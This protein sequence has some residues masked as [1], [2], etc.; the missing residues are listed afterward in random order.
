MSALRHPVVITSLEEDFEKIGLIKKEDRLEEGL[1]VSK[2][3]EV[4]SGQQGHAANG[5]KDGSE[6]AA[7]GSTTS[8]STKTK[9]GGKTPPGIPYTVGGDG[10]HPQ[11]GSRKDP[12][13]DYAEHMDDE[14]LEAALAEA[15]DWSDSFDEDFASIDAPIALLDENE[16]K[17]L[18]ACGDVEE[19][20]AGVFEADEALIAE[21]FDEDADEETEETET[22]ETEQP[23]QP[24]QPEPEETQESVAAE[25]LGSLQE[26]IGG[27]QETELSESRESTLPAFA[28]IALIA[29]MLAD[30][31]QDAGQALEDE[32]Y[33]QMAEGYAEMAKYS[34]GVVDF[35]ESEDDVDYEAVGATFGEFVETLVTGVEAFKELAKMVESD[36]DSDEEEE[37]D[38]GAYSKKE[39]SM[40]FGKKGKCGKKG[41]C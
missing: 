9:K 21:L 35:L 20:P 12:N 11:S 40:K 30:T 36:D 6:F 34:A 37:Q 29:E 23:E 18:E 26:R 13:H 22:E 24:E 25:F 27:L 16:M 33:A 8:K 7:K 1:P 39:M 14:E 10:M 4:G 38:E 32:E 41:E 19:L 5:S 28:N 3:G 15:S 17:E 2:G 31:F